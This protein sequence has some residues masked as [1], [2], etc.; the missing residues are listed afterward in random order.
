MYST[1]YIHVGMR[2]LPITNARHATRRNI[3]HLTSFKEIP[4]LLLVCICVCVCVCVNTNVISCPPSCKVRCKG[5]WATDEGTGQGTPYSVATE[6]GTEYG[7]QNMDH[8]HGDIKDVLIVCFIC[9]WTGSWQ[10][11]CICEMSCLSS[12]ARCENI[13]LK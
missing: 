1:C 2:V 3:K 8:E 10:D 11:G 4:N 6:A 13:T 7:V 9:C 5:W 12:W